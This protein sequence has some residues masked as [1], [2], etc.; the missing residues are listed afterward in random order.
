MEFGEGRSRRWPDVMVTKGVP[1]HLRS[2][3][4]PEFVAIGCYGELARRYGCEDGLYRA[5]KPVGERIL[6]K[7]QLE[8]AGRVPE[9]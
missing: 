5:G 2:D 9:R 6:R 1:E 8:A 7:L 3:N 4:G